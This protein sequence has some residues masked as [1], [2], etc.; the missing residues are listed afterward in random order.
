[1]P[2]AQICAG[3]PTFS[4]ATPQP[5]FAQDT[6]LNAKFPAQ[7][8]GQPVEGVQSGYYLAFLCAIGDQAQIAR[9]AA[10]LPG[11]NLAGLSF[12]SGRATIGG[13][14]VS[15]SAFRLP[16]G[17]ANQIIQHFAEFAVAIGADPSSLTGNTSTPAT[18]GGKNAYIFTDQDG[19]VTYVYPSG[20]TVWSTTGTQE[21]ADK[22]FAALP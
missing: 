21:Q 18:I 14:T 3:Q 22:I 1:V 4:L 16:G 8:D 19:D 12:G 10:A 11:T 7:I 6:D 5:S 9:F 2:P 17:D 13:E 20:D 15:I